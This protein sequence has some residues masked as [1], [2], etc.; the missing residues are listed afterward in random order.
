MKSDITKKGLA[1]ATHRAL[2]YSMGHC[3]EDLEKPIIGI[4][5]SQNETMPGHIH[6]DSVARAV[7]EGVLS[8]GGLPVEF[9]VIG[10]CDGIAQGNFG[11]HYPLASR[12]LIAD[13]IE[14]M[15]NAH[16]Y[17]A[18]VMVTNC[19]KIT[20]GMML[21]AVR[22]DVPA[23]IVSGGPMGTG[24]WEGRPF[25][26]ADLMSAQGRVAKKEMT[27]NDLAVMEQAALPGC[28]A[29]NMLG[30]ANSMNFLTEGL[31]L[32]LPGSDVPAVTGRR[33]ALAKASGRMIM[34]LYRQGITPRRIITRAALENAIALDLTIGGSSNT[35]L[36]LTALA[37]EAELEFDV[38]LFDR[39]SAKVPH[40][41]KISPAEGGHYPVD[42][43]TAG[44]IAAVMA[45]LQTAGLIREEA[46]T[47]TGRTV[48]ENLA[49]A[50]VLDPAVIR[51][52]DDPYS[53]SGGLRLLFGN[54][55]PEGAVC[56]KAAVNP[57]MY[58]H[59]GPARVF[60]QEEPAVEAIY[61]GRIKAGDVV[62]VRYEGPRGGPGMREMLTATAAIVG[63]GL[64]RETALIT[65]GRFSGSTSGAAIG[66]VSPEAA[67]GGPLALVRDGDL[68]SYDILEGRL[69]LEVE[70]A[71]LARRRADWRPRESGIPRGSYLRR[72]A[73][74]VSSAMSG[75][76]FKED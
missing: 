22:L 20:P 64:G 46:L 48:A 71:E 35:V 63:M 75:A 14:T 60:D 12:E 55:A 37:H 34:E 53:A 4:V 73:K 68:I 41:V 26:Y 28:G 13:S 21:A 54:L 65:D 70:E 61:D 38:R 51:P 39:M 32:C 30:T 2:Y 76:V 18:M 66:H 17:D 16:S 29:C 40:L 36:H 52:L 15:M 50:R 62:V 44:G 74:M 72:Y 31:G 1:R 8:A 23:I 25:G 59:R 6:L 69:T 11:M 19:D 7:R 27:M 49:A 43:H 42:I 58:A 24:C 47:V 45:R 57:A 5:N 9:P 3:P 10:V 67:S 56:K 33:L